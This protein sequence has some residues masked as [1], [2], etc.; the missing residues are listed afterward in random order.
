MGG[1]LLDACP[2]QIPLHATTERE[3][4]AVPDMTGTYQMKFDAN[5]MFVA[6][7]LNMNVTQVTG[8]TPVSTSYG[9]AQV[10]GMKG[11]FYTAPAIIGAMEPVFCVDKRDLYK[12]L[13]G[14]MYK[15]RGI[16]GSVAT[17][18]GTLAHHPLSPAITGG[19]RFHISNLRD[20]Q[21]QLDEP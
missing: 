18:R 9:V 12:K 15:V 21:G 10:G 2:N 16:K 11:T 5:S 19:C 1:S 7:S 4:F 14:F 8:Y 13:K 17:R 3:V 6:M 20:D